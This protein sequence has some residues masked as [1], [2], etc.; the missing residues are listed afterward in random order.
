M[1]RSSWIMSAAAIMLT[2][3]AASADPIAISVVSN[4]GTTRGGVRVSDS[5]G[6]DSDFQ[7][8][9]GE[10]PLS[11][12]AS[13]STASSAGTAS[14]TL[15]SLVG[16]TLIWSGSGT[17]HSEVSTPG[18]GS[19][20]ADSSLLVTFDVLA[21]VDYEFGAAFDG[22]ASPSGGS[23]P[24]GGFSNWGFGL[25]REGD[26]AAV[27]SEVGTGP[28]M[29]GF[30]G[31]LQP[32]RYILDLSTVQEVEV[33]G[34]AGLANGSFSFTV[35]FTPLDLTPPVDPAP[36]PEPTSLLLLGSGL[37]GVFRWRK[38]SRDRSC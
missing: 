35:H 1:N 15:T 9:S 5:S 7:T 22:E 21:T 27:F 25:R 23:L 34:R 14:A 38:R 6:T 28:A 37:V 10:G 19:F 12:T 29:R 32:G 26:V 2:A 36:V 20:F 18:T 4:Q 3:T 17:A 16:N 11:V 31:L 30:L 24:N 33:E 13:A 8:A